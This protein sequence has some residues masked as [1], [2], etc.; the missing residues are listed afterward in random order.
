MKKDECKNPYLCSILGFF[1][2]LIGLVI[3]AI[4]GKGEGVKHAFGGIAL[5]YVLFIGGCLYI[6]RSVFDDDFVPPNY[7]DEGQAN[8]AY[9]QNTKWVLDE[10]ISPIDDTPIYVLSCL[11]KENVSAII[12]DKQAALVVRHQEGKNEI[13]IDWPRFLSTKEIPVTVRFDSDESVTEKWQ[14]GTDHKSVF[15]PFPFED[16]YDLLKT[17]KKLVVRLTP[18][19]K[20]PEIAT[21][22][23]SSFNLILNSKVK[24]VFER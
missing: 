13:Y 15:S 20:S 22:D 10:S 2:P 1:L 8:E 16:F 5:R 6:T 17:S 24:D 7:N 12:K 4:I 14:C 23:L 18:H 11:S 19:G 21:F 3:S 9:T